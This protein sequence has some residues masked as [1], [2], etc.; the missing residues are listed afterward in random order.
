M[1]PNLPALLIAIILM[2]Y[3]GRVMRM[4][5]KARKVCGHSANLI[6]REPIG[7]L[8][9]II[10]FP[11]VILW[12]ALPLMAAWN[13]PKD[14]WFSPLFT[15]PALPWLAV[16][17]ATAALIATWICWKIMGKSWRMGIDPSDITPLV[18]QG[19]YSYVRHPIYALSSSLMLCTFVA[20][21]SLAMLIVAVGHISLL[22][23]EARREET[24]LYRVHGSE[25]E[26]Y[27][28]RVGKFLPN[29]RSLVR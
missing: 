26:E 12:V 29:L 4:A 9:R 18:T 28:A 21:P 23:S 19:P 22:L 10:W 16:L 20:V 1:P 25:Y 11:I 6:P 13:L 3:W 7:K 27:R 8:T 2:I 15:I 5:K 24:Y 14:P 17:V